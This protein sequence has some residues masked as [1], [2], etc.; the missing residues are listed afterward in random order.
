M[1]DCPEFLNISPLIVKDPI[2]GAATQADNINDKSIS[3]VFMK[4]I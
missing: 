3:S 2:G 4:S 1:S